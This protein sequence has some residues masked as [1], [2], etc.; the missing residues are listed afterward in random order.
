[1]ER[2][3]ARV[4]AVRQEVF[5]KAV[6]GRGIKVECELVVIPGYSFLLLAPA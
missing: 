1:M 2:S 4:F 6:S 3:T 5:L